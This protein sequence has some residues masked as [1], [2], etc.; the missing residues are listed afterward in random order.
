MCNDLPKEYNKC[1]EE[2]KDMKNENKTLLQVKKKVGGR[3][4]RKEERRNRLRHES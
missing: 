1:L 4:G 2:I 3:S